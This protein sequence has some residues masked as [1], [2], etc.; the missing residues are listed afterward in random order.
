MVPKS[1]DRLSEKIMPN[2]TITRQ[3]AYRA[4]CLRGRDAYSISSAVGLIATTEHQRD[5]DVGAAAK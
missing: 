5:E 2:K 4:G 3:P 1:G